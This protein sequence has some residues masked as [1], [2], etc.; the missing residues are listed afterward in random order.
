MAV[1]TLG[2]ASGGFFNSR[3][4]NQSPYAMG[5]SIV[6]QNSSGNVNEVIDTS[7]GYEGVIFTSLTIQCSGNTTTSSLFGN[8][9]NSIGNSITSSGTTATGADQSPPFS[10]RTFDISDRYVATGQT[11]YV[12]YS[13]NLS[14]PTAWDVVEGNNT[15]RTGNTFGSAPNNL[16]NSGTAG[17]FR[18]LV[19]TATYDLYEAGNISRSVDS[20][21]TSQPRITFAGQNGTLAKTITINWGDGSTNQTATIAASRNF[22]TSALQITKTAA[23]ANPGTYTITVTISFAATSVGIPDIVFTSTFYTPP[24]APQNLAA[25]AFSGYIYLT[26]DA[27]SSAPGNV[28]YYRIFRNDI[29]LIGDTSDGSTR[30]FSDSSVSPG[31]NY[32]YSVR[33]VAPGGDGPTATVNVTAQATAPSNVY[34]STYAISTFS[35]KSSST[36]SVI[37][38]VGATANGS[39]IT[40]YEYSLNSTSNWVSAGLPVSGQLTISG[41]TKTTYYTVYVRA[42]NEIGT[43][44]FTTTTWYSY[45]PVAGGPNQFSTTSFTHGGRYKL[46]I[47]SESYGQEWAPFYAKRYNGTAWVD[48]PMRIYSGA[49]WDYTEDVVSV[50][51]APQSFTATA[52]SSTQINL[53]WAAPV[54]NGG[55]TITSYTLKRGATT[56]YTG[57][58]TSFNDTGLSF[59]TS[60]SYTVLATNSIGDGPTAS[61]SRTTLANVPSAP[62][63][64]TATATSSSA[65]TLSWSAPSSNGG[66]SISSYTVRRNGSII[67][68]TYPPN[69]SFSDS[70]LAGSTNYSYTVAAN[71]SAGEGPTASASATTPSS[72]SV[73]DAPTISSSGGYTEYTYDENDNINGVYT[74]WFI[75]SPYT[76]NNGSPITSS[77]LVR[78][79]G[80]YVSTSTQSYPNGESWGP[81]YMVVDYENNDTT[82]FNVY[83]TN[84]IGNSAYSNTIGLST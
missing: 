68:T 42:V 3:A 2:T 58:N 44:P 20:P 9:W 17:F 77:T 33:A 29:G 72:A 48:A 74:V 30:Y 6:L 22:A 57:P 28:T 36:F 15:T 78:T 35:S 70:G 65:I 55:A 24:T 50:A 23:Y 80:P 84:A 12:G 31:A 26:W 71:N 14:A 21:N 53:S 39:A 37:L 38:Y 34:S 81:I 45:D 73:P 75:S 67:Y 27:P 76:N 60:Y 41:L 62:Q 40:R 46:R 47:D 51:T 49:V 59:A 1:I 18:R 5:S 10:A 13:R 64:F 52:A 69:T 19:G 16:T 66:A 32:T 56:I 4:A 25:T 79:D 54:S 61:I 83:H 43:S 11:V 8:I 63:S 7:G 82:Y